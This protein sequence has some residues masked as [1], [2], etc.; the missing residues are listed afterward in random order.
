MGD[1]AYIADWEGGL[2]IIDISNP[3]APTEIGFYATPGLA[4]A[5]TVA[6]NHAYS[7]D[8]NSGLRII[9]ISNPS[10]PTEVD[11]YDFSGYFVH[12][13]DVAVE[14]NYAYVAYGDLG[15]IILRLPAY[16]T[17]SSV[18]VTEGS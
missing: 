16:T 4:Q 6:G 17:T 7:A 8:G 10:A 1:Y 3:A 12:A 13:E 14:G 5:V 15:L 2:R 9:D 11:S 18:P